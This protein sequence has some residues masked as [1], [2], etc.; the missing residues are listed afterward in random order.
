MQRDRVIRNISV[1]AIAAVAMALVVTFFLVG[2]QRK[3]MNLLSE[4]SLQNIA[5]TQELYAETLRNKIK[6]QFK[7]LESQTE[8]FL[9]VDLNDSEAVRRRAKSLIS[10]GQFLR[11]AVV[12]EDGVAIDYNGRSLPNMKNKDYFSDALLTNF[13]QVSNQIELDERLN[14]CLILTV[15][16]TTNQGQ[17]GAVAGFFSYGILQQIFSLPIFSGQSYFYLVAKNGNILLYNKEKGKAIYN[18]DVCSYIERA[19]GMFNADLPEMKADIEKS[20]SGCITVNGG[21]GKKLFSYA[22]LKINEWTLITV[23]PYTYIVN[24]QRQISALVYILLASVAVTI[25][26]FFFII[27]MIAKSSAAIKKDNERLTIANNQAQTLIFEYDLHDGRVDFS[28]DTSFMFGTDRKSYPIEFFRSEYYTRIHPEDGNLYERIRLAM[29]GG[30]KNLSAEF[31]YKGFSGVYFW[32]KLSGSSV[33]DEKGNVSKFIGSIT[34]VNSQVLREQELRNIA[35]SDRLSS[36]LNKSA[37]ERRSREYLA[38]DGKER[39]SALIIIDLDNFKEV[40]DNLGHMTGDLAI[41]DAAKKISLIFSEKD[42]L[43]RFGGDEFCVLMRFDEGLS[44]EIALKIINS[45]ASDLTRSLK[46]DYFNDEHSVS[47]SASVGISIFPYDGKGYEELFQIADQALYD[48]KQHGKDGF[49]IAGM[50]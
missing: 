31:R 2:F 44:E 14:P 3:M 36:L 21:E 26:I 29:N 10:T 1:G 13:R 48:V 18:I 42:F 8:Y 46:E 45:K 28:G 38:R 37:F 43:G 20:R 39:I 24:Q 15:P 30:S 33:F 7:I 19:A 25:I 4:M 27:Y 5:E 9:D 41:Q 50:P 22:P 17:K 16:F 40:N 49:K 11:I 6:D 35:D 23:L 12:N 32:V 47:V 34:N